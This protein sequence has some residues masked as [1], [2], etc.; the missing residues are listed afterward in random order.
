MSVITRRGDDG[1]TDFMFGRRCSKNSLRVQAYGAVDELNSALGLA[2]ALGLGAEVGELVAAVQER[3][4]PLMGELATLP[5]DM[6]EY[7]RRGYASLGPAD[8]AWAEAQAEAL[9]QRGDIH[10]AGWARP[11]QGAGPGAAALDLAR[12]VCRRAERAVL[13]LHEAQPV[14]NA[15]ILIFLNRMSDVLWLA[16]RYEIK[17]SSPA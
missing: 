8:V 12:A 3:L 16:A 10:F 17:T 2:L 15:S 6:A 13:A 5:E 4:V 11:G 9:E 7:R 1:Q 14:P